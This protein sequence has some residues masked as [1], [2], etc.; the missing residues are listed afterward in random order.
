MPYSELSSG[1]MEACFPIGDADVCSQIWVSAAVLLQ[2][3]G[4]GLLSTLASLG[5][6]GTCPSPKAL[7]AENEGLGILI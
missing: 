1:E 6:S 7:S 5:S 2:S 3:L 4:Q